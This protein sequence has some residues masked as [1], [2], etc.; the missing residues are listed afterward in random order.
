MT[1]RTVMTE[2]QL[3][4][5]RS[6]EMPCPKCGA[7]PGSPCKSPSGN[8]MNVAHSARW[9]AYYRLKR[10]QE[11]LAAIKALSEHLLRQGQESR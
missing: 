1:K 8:H 5:I 11:S 10:E 3:R 4:K 7:D 9:A 6:Q 2:K